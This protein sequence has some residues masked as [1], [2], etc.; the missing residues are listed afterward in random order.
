MGGLDVVLAD[1]KRIPRLTAR[2]AE[3]DA[4]EKAQRADVDKAAERAK[5]LPA[6]ID[7]VVE[8]RNARLV[9]ASG[10][11]DA[12]ERVARLAASRESGCARRRSEARPRFRACGREEGE[13][14][15]QGGGRPIRR[16]AHPSTRGARGRARVETRRRRTVRRLRSHRAPEPHRLRQRA[17]RADLR[18]PDRRAANPARVCRRCPGRGGRG[19][20]RPRCQT[21]VGDLGERRALCPPRSTPTSSRPEPRWPRPSRPTVPRSPSSRASPSC[22]QNSHRSPPP[23]TS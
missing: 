7:E 3:Y 2:V 20:S 12:E 10:R 5:T 17:G 22:E 18:R 23:S 1:E 9:E 11:S 21:R 8:Q 13:H 6:L 14:G 15:Q 4:T 16:P 19:G